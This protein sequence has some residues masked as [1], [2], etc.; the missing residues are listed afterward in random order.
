MGRV[1][2]MVRR[3]IPFMRHRLTQNEQQLG[4]HLRGNVSLH[5]AL[6]G[7]I[8]TRVESRAQVQ[9]PAD[10]VVCKSMMARDRELQWLKSRLDFVFQSPVLEP[11]SDS[12]Q[13]E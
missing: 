9:E 1:S 6:V 3:A 11:A 2:D 4:V 7:L 10:P 13:P 5:N 12:E 8:Q